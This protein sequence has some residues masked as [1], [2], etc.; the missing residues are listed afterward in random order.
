MKSAE[1]G[2]HFIGADVH[3]A[4]RGDA[5]DAGFDDDRLARTGIEIDQAPGHIARVQL[6][7]QMAGAVQRLNNGTGV[8][9]ALKAAAG[10]RADAQAPCRDAGAAAV[11]GGALKQQGFCPFLDLA[12]ESSHDAGQTGRPFP[13]AD[14]Q[15]AACQMMFLFVKRCQLFAGQGAQYAGMGKNL[16]ETSPAARAVM[17]E[18]E[19]LRAGTLELCFAGSKD[20]LSKTLNTQPCLM[21]VDCACAAALMERGIN[22][23]GLA[24]FSLGEIAAL[25]IGKMLTFEQAFTLVLRRAEWMQACAEQQESGMVAVLKLDDAA[26]EALCAQHHAYPVNYNCPGQVVCAMRNVDTAAFTAAV[27]EAGGRALPLAVNG[28]F[29]SPLMAD[30][31][32]NMRRYAAG[33]PIQESVMPLYA[34][35]TC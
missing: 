32:D 22:P 17:D 26:V 3:P 12:F 2:D 34:D 15:L 13:V 35:K 21:A 18:A 25:A 4:A 11:E 28:G 1:N 7:Y 8:D 30:A 9:A 24:G 27:K 5:L 19:R 14:Q 20:D 6:L 33:L 23:D 29:H 16:Y 10:L 31:A